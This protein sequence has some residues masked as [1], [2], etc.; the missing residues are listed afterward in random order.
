MRGVWT[1]GLACA[2][3][4]WLASSAMAQSEADPAPVQNVQASLEQEARALFQAGRVVER[5]CSRGC[6]P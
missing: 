3:C 6:S 4:G 2:F 5:S 1:V